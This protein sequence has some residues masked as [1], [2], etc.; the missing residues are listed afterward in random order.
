[1]QKPDSSTPFYSQVLFFFFL[2]QAVSSMLTCT[3]HVDA[4]GTMLL[5]HM[6][7]DNKEMVNWTC[8]ESHRE[9]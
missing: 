3:E 4:G 5:N 1:M 2:H 9:I 8:P 6:R 7:L